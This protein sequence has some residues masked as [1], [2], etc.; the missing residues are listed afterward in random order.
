MATVMA[1][2]IHSVATL[3]SGNS[4]GEMIIL[5]SQCASFGNGHGKQSAE[6]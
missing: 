2:K 3:T 4:I 6:G 1:N 5:F